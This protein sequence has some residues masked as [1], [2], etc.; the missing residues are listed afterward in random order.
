MRIALV[1]PRVESLGSMIPPL[2]LL[3]IGGV[4]ERDGHEVKIFDIYPYDDNDLPSLAAYRAD[5][6]GMTV[7]TDYW[8]RAVQV[9][10]FI[11]R[12]MPDSR[13]VIGGV[14]VTMLPGEAIRG[15]GAMVGVIGEGEYTMR[16]L[17][18]HFAAG[19]DWRGEDGIA[20]LDDGGELHRTANRGF[21]ANLDE[22]PFPARHLLNFENYLIPPG[23]VRGYWSERSTVAMTS[24]GCP[25]QCIWC[26]SQCTFGR[27]VRR[28]TV[29]NVMLEVKELVERYRL[30][31]LYFID[32]TFTLN[33]DWVRQ[34]CERLM[35]DGYRIA[36]GCQAH[37]ETV[38]EDMLRLMKKAGLVQ[39][40][41]GVESGSDRVL[42]ALKKHSNADAVRRA[43]AIARK[44]GV[45]TMASF[46]LGS[47]EET[48]EDIEDTFKLAKEIRP[49]YASAYFLTPYPGTELM[50]M[51]KT[52][53]WLASEDH[54][55]GGLRKGPMM[56]INFTEKEL[57]QI[58]ARFQKMF[59]WRNVLSVAFSPQYFSRSIW[60]L[61]RYPVGFAMGIARFLKTRA[62]DDFFFVFYNYYLR[63]RTALMRARRGQV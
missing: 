47:P 52:H 18:R 57:F 59:V 36:W 63:R 29:D 39:L 4:L 23:I 38:E 16:A 10:E 37:V 34:F 35:A 49:N 55:R 27:G 8:D 43:F 14:H 54:N 17:C 48:W 26:G 46:V 12:E 13:F 21:I 61:L 5:V 3:W 45:R 44:V 24:R 53:G 60:M 1:N 11:R 22:L 56:R 6:V 7:L 9:A 31:T 40:D 20:Y 58:R 19:T 15:L 2:G 51:A 41:M 25:F 33:R 28:R 62:I 30:D 50:S 32:D 42:K